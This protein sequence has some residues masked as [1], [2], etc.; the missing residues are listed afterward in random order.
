MQKEFGYKANLVAYVGEREGREGKDRREEKR[1]RQRERKREKEGR[2]RKA[3]G[4]DSEEGGKE[5]ECKQERRQKIYLLPWKAGL[6][7]GRACLLK[8]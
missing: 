2:E 8:G 3:L 5:R 4:T 7:V 6:G 1:E